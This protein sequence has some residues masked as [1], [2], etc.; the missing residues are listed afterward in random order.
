MSLIYTAK[1]QKLAKVMLVVRAGV[2]R[3]C[4]KKPGVNGAA[5]GVSKLI[6]VKCLIARKGGWERLTG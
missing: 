6:G 1:G 2:P 5:N 3:W 4:S